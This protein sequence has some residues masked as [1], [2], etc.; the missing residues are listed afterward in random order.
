MPRRVYQEAT[1]RA[2]ID[3]L[4]TGQRVAEVADAQRVPESTVRRWNSE[5]LAASP[6]GLSAATSV[7]A[8]VVASIVDRQRPARAQR[9]PV[10]SE[11]LLPTS[12]GAPAASPSPS[13]PIRASR[14]RALHFEESHLD[15]SAI[16]LPLLDAI[17]AE[18]ERRATSA[19][20]I[21]DGEQFSVMIDLDLRY[22]E[23]RE[24]A[25]VRVAELIDQVVLEV[26]GSTGQTPHPPR[27]TR[28]WNAGT[29]YVFAWLTG[30]QLLEI[31]RRDT[32]SNLDTRAIFR[33]WP[34][35]PVEPLLVRS[36]RT[37][38]G[39]AAANAF[40]A[41]GDGIVWAV[42]DSGIQE[43]HL[44]FSTYGNL[45][46]PNGVSHMDFTDADVASPLT[47]AFGHGTHVAAII[48]G[49]WPAAGPAIPAPTAL[50]WR[51]DDVNRRVAAQIDV[52]GIRGVAPRATL[53][54]Y[55]V[56]DDNGRSD[57]SRVIAAL[58]HI[59]RINEG[60]AMLRIHG[61]NLSIGYPFDPEWYACGESLLCQAVNR[62]VKSGVVV[63]CAAGNSGYGVLEAEE[64][65]LRRQGL[66]MSI[67]DPANA[68]LA[69]TVGSTHREE[70]HRYGA[71]YFSS[72]GPT[73]DGRAKPDLV[74]PGEKV[75]SANAQW[76][77][78]APEESPTRYPYVE[79][80]GTSA[81]APHVS[82]AI[83]AFLSVRREF[84][85]RADFV[86]K[87][88]MRTA[89]DLERDRYLQGAGLLDLTRAIHAV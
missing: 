13:P 43:S 69:L 60:G 19:H 44:H 83:A 79:K 15:R 12:A 34:N 73:G 87:L 35:H 27:P 32:L 46:L 48:A 76:V 3:A 39:D 62:L 24:K 53:V 70:P 11:P 25:R 51:R 38:K 75:L 20:V 1:V 37:I 58:D 17:M 7:I 56:V 5:L 78:G 77:P 28:L 18:R 6:E 42:I 89:T 52:T 36:V 72:K 40:G 21:Q 4:A 85:G 45:A 59:A 16:A 68:E 14:P 84:V 88:F 74:A 47:D 31:V 30:R 22:T 8:M 9:E 81:A 65:G 63:V 33:I 2:V 80:S 55:K 26:P 23:G 49:E 86:K 66:A 57:A 54:S 82:G 41:N 50:S 29:N 64:G 67:H 10:S 61:V 71:S